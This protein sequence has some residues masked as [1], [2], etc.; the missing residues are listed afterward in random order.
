[1][2]DG[3]RELKT[4]EL[5]YPYD[6]RPP[7]VSE[8]QSDNPD[9]HKAG[10]AILK[11]I[12]EHLE[13]L[14]AEK[15]RID[16][17]RQEDAFAEMLP[18]AA[19]PPG[20]TPRHALPAAGKQLRATLDR[21]ARLRRRVADYSAHYN[22]HLTKLKHALFILA[23]SSALLFSL[24]DNWGVMKGLSSL[25]QLFFATAFGLTLATWIVF[26][27]FKKTAAVERCEDYRA[28][29]EGLRV[30]FYWTASGSGE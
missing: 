16:P 5:L 10:H 2:R 21:L 29:T 6:C 27:R 1:E 11:V 9:W 22:G 12:A 17:A 14:N 24:A 20:E 28:I 13:R 15:I 23:F 7:E 8:S 25:P 19:D 26:F 4:M 30:Q 18:G 3:D